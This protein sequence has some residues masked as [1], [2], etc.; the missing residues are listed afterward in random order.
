[1]IT[2][3]DLVDSPL[4]EG[5]LNPTGSL[6]RPE[7]GLVTV[8]VD[9]DVDLD[10]Y[11]RLRLGSPDTDL[12][13][14]LSHG[15]TAQIVDS[16]RADAGVTARRVG[17]SPDLLS[18]MAAL[19]MAGVPVTAEALD[20]GAAIR[21]GPDLAAILT[22]PVDLGD[23]LRREEHSVRLRRAALLGH[24]SLAWRDRLASRAGLPHRAFR[25][26]RS[27]W[28]PSGRTSSRSLCARWTANV[29]PIS[30]SWL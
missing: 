4:D 22:S 13:L 7:H 30:S 18:S 23:P 26:A 20:P 3:P 15:V 2:D 14:N 10:V 27:S 11:S 5:V 28:R 6:Q 29:A 25:P 1:M 9:V 19:S 8:D 12:D 17:T 16:L 21:L 24:S